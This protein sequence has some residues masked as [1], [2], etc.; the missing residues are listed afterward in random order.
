VSIFDGVLVTVA[1]TARK[2]LERTNIVASTAVAR[3]RKSA[4]ATRA[5]QARRAAAH[6]EAAAFERCIRIT[7]TSEPGDQSREG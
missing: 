2:M 5:H 1:R 7:M 6:A 3:V 4:G